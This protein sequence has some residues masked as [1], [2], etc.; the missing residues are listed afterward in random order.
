MIDL[1]RIKTLFIDGQA[2]KELF[3]DGRKIWSKPSLGCTH[4][5]YFNGGSL[6]HSLGFDGL[7]PFAETSMTWW[8]KT[9]TQTKGAMIHY[10][11]STSS[12]ISYGVS[13]N[14]LTTT[15]NYARFLCDGVAWYNNL[16]TVSY[17]WH[18]YG[19]VFKSNTNIELY[20]DGVRKTTRTIST[21]RLYRYDYIPYEFCIGGTKA[22]DYDHIDNRRH[23][24]TFVGNIA[25]FCH[26]NRALTASEIMEDKDLGGQYPVGADH[27]WTMDYDQT[28]GY[29]K[30]L[31][32]GWDVTP[33]FGSIEQS[34]DVPW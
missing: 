20:L 24:R 28:T 15:G 22:F 32:G 1:K 6:Y 33:R 2:V 26:F 5:I 30:D 8:A 13:G 29:C 12:G 10:G 3:A 18:H 25:R 19:I 11:D 9:S 23:D 17:G 31:I 7:P 16:F 4:S 27:F 21:P 34:D 14:E